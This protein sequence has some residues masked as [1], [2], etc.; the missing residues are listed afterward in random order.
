V[1]V[2][3]TSAANSGVTDTVTNR[4]LAIVG[5]GV[6]LT[7]TQ[8]LPGA[9]GAGAGPEA[10]PI[11]TVT[12]DSSA[13]VNVRLFVNNTGPNPDSFNLEFSNVGAGFNPGVLPANVA[14]I[15]FFIGDGDGNTTGVPITSTGQIA[16]VGNKEI[17]ASVTVSPSVP[18]GTSSDLFFRVISGASSAADIIHDRLT[19]N[20][21]RGISLLQNQNG[22]T[23]AGAANTY[24][25]VLRNL[26]NV[27]EPQINLAAINSQP[28][29]LTTIYLDNDGDGLINGAD[30]VITNVAGFVA[31]TSTSLIIR[32]S[33]PSSAANGAVDTMTLTATPTGTVGGVVAPAAQ[34]NIDQTTVVTGQIELT[35]SASPFGSQPPTTVITYTI[36]YQNIGAASVTT[37][38]ITDGIPVN[39][40]Y[41]A[42]S[43][44]VNGVIKTDLSDADEG[45]LI[46]GTKGSVQFDIGNVLAGV[47]GAVSFRVTID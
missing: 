18:G 42:G 21:V 7:N 25:H 10:S 6:D 5:P 20:T 13:T 14:A 24:S 43:L 33:A 32:V 19:V 26:G 47:I 12:G 23:S 15:L 8:A 35:L 29:F 11:V 1:T 27:T 17:I 16:A 34:I 31:G 38:R 41:V 28:G 45:V 2:T 39:T 46:G 22:Q 40:T 44:V 37:L 3:A 4:L 30:A 9:P 36:S